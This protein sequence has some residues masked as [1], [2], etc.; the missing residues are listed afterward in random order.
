[1]VNQSIPLSAPPGVYT[2]YAICGKY[3]DIIPEIMIDTASFQFTVIPGE[4]YGG[5]SDWTLS[6]WFDENVSLEI[7]A[8]FTLLGNYPNP[9]NAGTT[10]SYTLPEKSEVR[11]EVYNL[12]GQ[13]IET[14]F[15]GRQQAGEYSVMWDAS[16]FASGI[17]IYRLTAGERVF[18]KRMTLVK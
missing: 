3:E 11:L 1:G 2:Y 5:A 14:L 16:G 15:E 8:E 7:P 9:F 6:G 10:I 18:S 4:I 13:L 12:L 17:Y